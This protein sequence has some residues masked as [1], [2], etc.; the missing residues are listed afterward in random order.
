MYLSRLI[1]NPRNRDA[2]RDVASPYDLHR[3]I[4]RVFETPEGVDYRAYHQV[5][6]RIEPPSFQAKGPIVLVS[7]SVLPD[8]HELPEEYLLEAD[9]KFRQPS[10]TIGQ[11]LAFRLVANPTRKV[12]RPGQRQGRR[13]GLS[14]A[15]SE[16]GSSPVLDWLHRK[17]RQ[18]GFKVMFA[19]VTPFVMHERALAQPDK[20]KAT[21]WGARFDGLLLVEEAGRFQEALERGVGP[22]KTFGFGLLT[23]APAPYS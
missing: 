11:T 7:S 18:H 9:T 23:V 19:T 17:G 2:R 21:F 4:A 16:A 22:A 20:G 14:D 3:T 12:K 10:F 13:M 1:L 5:L 15:V 8:W 6:F